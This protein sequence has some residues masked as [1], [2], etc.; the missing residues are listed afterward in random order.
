MSKSLKVYLTVLVLL[1]IGAV[2]FELSK[3]VP[4]NWTPSFNEKHTTPYGLQIFRDELPGLFKDHPVKNIYVTPYEYFDSFYNPSDSLYDISGSYVYVN[5]SYNLDEISTQEL[6]Y[7][8]DHGNSI[9]ISAGDLPELLQDSLKFTLQYNYNLKGD[10]TLSFSNP[11]FNSD[12]IYISKGLNH[13]YFTSLDS[14]NTTVLGYQDFDKKT[15]NFVKI[16]YGWGSFYLHTQPYVFTNYH[17]LKENHFTY[18]EAVLSY[19]PD[20]TVYFDSANNKGATLGSSPLRFIFSQPALKWAWYLLLLTL[21]TFLI[22][23]AKRKQR[24]VPIRKPLPNTTVDFTKTIA[25]LYYETKDHKNMID[26][27]ITYFLAKIRSDYLIHTDILDEQFANK[28]AL[29]T[30]KPKAVVLKLINLIVYLQKKKAYSEAHLID[31]NKQIEEFYT[32]NHG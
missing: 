24:V 7:F 32:E 30:G 13:T 15:I 12:S 18:T 28:L 4:V 1:V 21:V 11:Q 19:L 9:F 14:V 6:L 17:L 23:N 5:A 29:K 8:A 3:P 10:A 25:N 16:N 27:K 22:F 20:A 2:L 31:L 26:K